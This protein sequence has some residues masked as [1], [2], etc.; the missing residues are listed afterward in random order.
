MRFLVFIYLIINI[1]TFAKSYD[2]PYT[3]PYFATILAT[4]LEDMPEFTPTKYKEITLPPDNLNIP[5]NLWYFKNF[6]FGLMAQDEKAPLIFLFAG[7]GAK[8][9]SAKMKTMADILYSKG[10]S[11]VMLPTSFD[12]NYLVTMSKTHAPGILGDDGQEIYEVMKKVMKK[13]EKKVDYDDIYVTGYSLGGSMALVIGEIDS[14]EKYFNFKRIVSINPTV[15]LYESATLLDKLLDDN[16]HG[17]N[18]L[19]DLL[20]KI[21]LGALQYGDKKGEISLDQNTIYSLFESLNMKEEDLKILI[22]IAFRIISID[23]NYLSDLMTGSGVYTD[24][25]KKI[26]KYE[27]MSQYYNSINYSNFEKYIDKIGYPVY[28]KNHKNYSLEDVIKISGLAYIEKYLK[29]ATNIAVITNE[30]E[31]IL[32]K[33]NL[34]YLKETLGNK[35]K[36]YP[37]GGHCGNMF[38][39]D[40]IDFMINYLLRGEI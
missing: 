35:V 25:S 18:E 17:E 31:L 30:D 28:A 19:D 1:V 23:I 4:P 6:K 32:T 36:V 7:T 40:N 14:R 39:K 9:N 26:T 10:F 5:E 33:D 29:T 15:N 3:D 34:N 38:Y 12:Y 27:S 22:G 24:P 21:I 2:Y 20:R 11:V 13:I 8:Y 37:H 16:I